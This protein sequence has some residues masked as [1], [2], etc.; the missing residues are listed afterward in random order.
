MPPRDPNV[1]L[2]DIV[3]SIDRILEYTASNSYASFAQDR[4]TIDAVLRNFEVL[5]EAARHVDAESMSRLPAV[6]WRDMADLRNLL[7]HE[8]FG[9]SL[10]IVWAT[11]ERDL[12]PLRTALVS[13]LERQG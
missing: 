2:R 8:Y 3:D 11:I 10:E 13:E 5:G 9:V 12:V 4:R 7:I 1:R 6:P